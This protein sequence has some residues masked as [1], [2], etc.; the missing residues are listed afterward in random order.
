[1]LY[2]PKRQEEPKAQISDALGKL[3][4][5]SQVHDTVQNCLVNSE[6]L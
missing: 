1:M 5:Q 2:A 4:R 3:T 6:D